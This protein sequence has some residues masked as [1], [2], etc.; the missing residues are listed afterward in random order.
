MAAEEKTDASELSFTTFK[1]LAGGP[2]YPGMLIR[3]LK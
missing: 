1:T 2:F 3:Q